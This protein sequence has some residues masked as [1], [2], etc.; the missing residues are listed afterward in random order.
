MVAGDDWIEVGP[1][2]KI[3]LALALDALAPSWIR[4]TTR[5]VCRLRKR[6]HR[7]RR[8]DGAGGECLEQVPSGDLRHGVVPGRRA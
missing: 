7:Q 3:G 5:R 6:Q 8:R 4:D 2:A 1:V